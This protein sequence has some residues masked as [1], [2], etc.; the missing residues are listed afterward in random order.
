[1]GNGESRALGNLESVYQHY[2]L[3]TEGWF[4]RSLLPFSPGTG[5][6]TGRGPPCLS[7]FFVHN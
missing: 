4:N 2:F 1:M 7:G 6:R 3:K 5:R